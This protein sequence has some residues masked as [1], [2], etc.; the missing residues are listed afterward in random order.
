MTRSQKFFLVVLLGLAIGVAAVLNNYQ[1]MNSTGASQAM[2]RSVS[3]GG[4]EV[5]AE[6]VDTPY[7]LTRGLSGRTSL[8]PG[9]GMLFVFS[10]EDKWGFWMKDMQFPIDII[11]ADKSGTVVSVASDV[12]PKS[13]PEIFY[14]SVPAQYVL[15]VPVGFVQTHAIAK[16]MKIVVQ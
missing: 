4:V 5:K 8:P 14:P 16:G 6:V 7:T 9:T 3:V 15:E 2:S 13:Y 11:W 10:N 12:E 1:L